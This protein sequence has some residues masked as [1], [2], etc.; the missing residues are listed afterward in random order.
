MP[1]DELHLNSVEAG[2]MFFFCKKNEMEYVAGR[3][4]RDV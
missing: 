2:Q 1:L 4:P 3:I